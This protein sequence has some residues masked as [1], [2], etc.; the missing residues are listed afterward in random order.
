[1]VQVST[2]RQGDSPVAALRLLANVLWL[3][4][5]G[6]PLAF[7]YALAGMVACVLII[8]I[9]FGIAALKMAHLSLFPLGKDIVSTHARR[10]SAESR[11]AAA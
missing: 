7:G 6:L 11:T 2:S 1:M 8:G 9:P 3:V 4:L 10:S 5:V